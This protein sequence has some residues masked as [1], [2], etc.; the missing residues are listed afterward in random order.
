M[1]STS[2]LIK[3]YLWMVVLVS[4]A[5]LGIKAPGLY[6]L[7]KGKKAIAVGGYPMEYGITGIT[8]T[9]CMPSCF[10]LGVPTCCSAGALCG[11]ALPPACLSSDIKGAMAGGSGA[12]ILMSMSAVSASGVS[13]GGQ[14]ICGAA[15]NVLMSACYTDV[16]M[17][18]GP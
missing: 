5:F 4:F 11:A 17:S 16:G 6:N 7:Y 1:K 13:A 2:L 10:V 14:I 18:T 3:T 9:P 15:S 8:I 12:N